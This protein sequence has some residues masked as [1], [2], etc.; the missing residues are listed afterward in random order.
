MLGGCETDSVL[1]TILYRKSLGT[2]LIQIFVFRH[3]LVSKANEWMLGGSKADSVFYTDFVNLCG[4]S[5]ST[6]IVK[7]NEHPFIHL[8][9]LTK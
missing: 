6:Q 1:K 3:T 5:E 7:M 2:G 4:S 9:N 8:S